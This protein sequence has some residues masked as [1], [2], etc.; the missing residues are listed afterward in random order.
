[1][2]GF[3]TFFLIFVFTFLLLLISTS[4]P[5]YQTNPYLKI[6]TLATEKIA[7]TS[8]NIR[9][10]FVKYLSKNMLPILLG[11]VSPDPE[12]RAISEARLLTLLST[13]EL[14][15]ENNDLL[16]IDLWCGTT[17]H[18]ELNQI[19]LEST[20]QRK[21]IKCQNCYDLS[22][23]ICTNYIKTDLSSKTAQLSNFQQN[24][25]IFGGFGLTICSKKGEICNVS[26]IPQELVI[27]LESADLDGG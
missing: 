22:A 18:T 10:A 13:F 9:Q 1:M 8:S 27:H 25:L 7:F 14:I 12:T 5:T 21:P 24:P 3:F 4:R 17:P 23:P 15:A 19:A 2:K 6:N 16:N 20:K 26:K 11:R